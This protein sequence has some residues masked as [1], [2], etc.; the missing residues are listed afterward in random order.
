M[1][2]VSRYE[3]FR[4]PAINNVFDIGIHNRW[5]SY[6]KRWIQLHELLHQDKSQFI[7]I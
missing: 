3:Y 7:S 2:A 4:S 1:L 6:I 5:G